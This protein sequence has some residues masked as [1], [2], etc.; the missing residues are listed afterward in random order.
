LPLFSGEA[1]P[2]ELQRARQATGTADCRAGVDDAKVGQLER[3]RR[4]IGWNTF[5]G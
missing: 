5:G 2:V 4:A 1:G 3:D